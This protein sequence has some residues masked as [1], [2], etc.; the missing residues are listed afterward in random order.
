MW[1]DTLNRIKG[2]HN[3]SSKDFAHEL[4]RSSKYWTDL[5]SGNRPLPSSEKILKLLRLLEKRNY[6]PEDQIINFLKDIIKHKLGTNECLL[7][8]ELETRIAKLL[9]ENDDFIKTFERF[10][11][12]NL[13]TDTENIT[14]NQTLQ[15]MNKKDKQYLARFSDFITNNKNDDIENLL[16]YLNV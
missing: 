14:I 16:T 12:V 1:R 6:L 7:L 15:L 4:G 10:Y 8:Y 9:I 13:V 5:L 2:K 11:S 3:L